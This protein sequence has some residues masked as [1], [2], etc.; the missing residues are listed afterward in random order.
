MTL[1]ASCPLLKID[2][3]SRIPKYQQIVDSIIHSIEKGYLKVGDKL[4]SIN[5][6]SEEYYLSRDTVVRA[7]NQLREKQIITSVVS[8]GFYVNKTVNTT[9]SKVLFV[10]NKLSNYKLTIYNTFVN[11]M[12]SDHQVDLRIY[13]CDPKLLVNILEENAGA[14]DHFVVMPHFKDENSLHTSC[15]EEVISCLKN[16]PKEKLVIMDNHIPE[17]GD[18]VA[19]IYQDFKMDIYRALEESKDRLK[20]YEKLILVFPDNNIYPYPNDIKQG[21]LNF[22]NTHKFDGEVLDKIYPE[23]ELQPRDAY[24]LID[25]NDLVSLVQQTRDLRLQIGT[26]IGVVSYND[27]PLKELFDITVFSTDFELMGESA[28]YMIKKDKQEVVPNIFS[29]IDR[30]SL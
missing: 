10:L 3:E 13:H 23:M 17:M 26:D 7:Y 14:Y 11:S 29:F 27:T 28:A 21:F 5:D 25:E 15:D 24:I 16:I 30:G 19:C 20:K 8:K 9:N 6:I 22:C 2:S 18:D 1:V 4:P 12:G